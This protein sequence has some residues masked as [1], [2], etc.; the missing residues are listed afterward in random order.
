MFTM[1]SAV[2]ELSDHVPCMS[3]LM[4][5]A[6]ESSQY[7]NNSDLDSD[8]TIVRELQNKLDDIYSVLER[9]AVATEQVAQ[10]LLVLTKDGELRK[11]EG[12]N[13]T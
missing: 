10:M 5:M 1:A 9:Q 4:A 12:L 8:C 2:R 11:K 6:I 13:S 7:H 3:L